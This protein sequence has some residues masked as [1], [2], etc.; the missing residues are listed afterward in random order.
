MKELKDYV[1]SMPNFPEEGIIFRDIT[2]V[3]QEAEG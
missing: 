1:R 3:L 2:T